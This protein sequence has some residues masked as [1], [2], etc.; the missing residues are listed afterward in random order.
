MARRNALLALLLG[1]LAIAAAYGSA[2]LP[3][4]PP[5]WAAWAMGMGTAV[6]M[7][8]SMAL[9]AVNRGSIGRLGPAFAG[10]FGVLAAGFALAL[11]LP[12]EAPGA[13]L[14]LGLPLR[15]AIVLIGVGLVPLL[16]LPLSYAL[17][18]EETTL[19]EQDLE[20]VREA[21]RQLRGPAARAAAPAEP[22]LAPAEAV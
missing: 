8:A 11:V 16:F 9:G 4:D 2:F 5:A 21:A 12:P 15:A 20:R 19:S 3:G 13:P 14:F 6:V 1:T 18:F 10:V 7:V 22:A 17:T